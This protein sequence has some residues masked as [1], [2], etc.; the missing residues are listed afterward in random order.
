MCVEEGNSC[1][2][3]PHQHRHKQQAMRCSCD[4]G[5][6]PRFLYPSLLLLLAERRSYG[7]EL[8]SRLKDVGYEGVL[9]DPASVYKVLRRLEEDGAVKSEWDTSGSGPAKRVYS[10]TPEGMDMLRLWAVSIA[11]AKKALE[12]FL[13][14][15][16]KRFG[17][18]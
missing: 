5:T 8:I 7:Y 13:E 3:T 11:D 6:I 1:C 2:S 18:C 16:Q 9:P 17:T 15:F 12:K 14:A 10:I 4:L